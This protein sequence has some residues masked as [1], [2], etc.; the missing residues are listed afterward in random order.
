MMAALAACGVSD[1]DKFSAPLLIAELDTDTVERGP[2]LTQD[3][4]EIFFVTDYVEGRGGSTIMTATRPDASTPF[5]PASIV[6]AVDSAA[7]EQHPF[8]SHDGL[9]LYFSRG[10]EIGADMYVTTRETRQSPW[11]APVRASELESAA[12]DLAVGIASDDLMLALDS[13]RGDASRDLY[14]SSRVDASQPW[15]EPR[16]I[17]E[18]DTSAQEKTPQLVDGGRTL[19]FTRDDDIFVATRPDLSS[20]FGAPVAVDELDTPMIELDPWISDD[21]RTIVFAS[22]RGTSYALYVA[23]R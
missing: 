15:G 21:Q 18:L 10:S 11:S 22:N 12:D 17:V 9:H 7:F 8:V 20:P 23:T 1:A 16:P 5:G 13:T 2:A 6:T 3:L 4:L 14:L 19:W